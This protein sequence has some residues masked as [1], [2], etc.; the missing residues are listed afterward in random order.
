MNSL[1]EDI[2][3]SL[4]QAGQEACGYMNCKLFV[5]TVTGVPKLDE[6]PSKPFRSI[7]DLTIGDVLK[8][9]AGQH[10]AIYIGGGDIMEVEEWGAES[11]IVPLAEILE[12]MDPPDTVFSTVTPQHEVLLREYIRELLTEVAKGPQDLPDGLFVKIFDEGEKVLVQYVEEDG[13]PVQDMHPREGIP[14]GT[15]TMYKSPTGNAGLIGGWCGDAWVVMDSGAVPG[16]GP[17][18]Y[19][20]AMEFATL[21]GGGLFS[22]RGGVSPSARKVWAYY[23][24]S[25]PDVTAHQLD[26]PENTLTPEEEDNCDQT[27]AGFEIEGPDHWDS[28]RVDVDWVKSPLSKRYTAPPTMMDKLSTAGRLMES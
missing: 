14:Y 21:N 27:V 19:D 25:R 26:D 1:R 11:R 5:Q 10:W 13:N 4:V 23:M 7:G 15:V 17:M 12:E 16:W 9:G 3:D 28:P 2:R 22:D 24:N 20:V 6:L 18:L 8:W